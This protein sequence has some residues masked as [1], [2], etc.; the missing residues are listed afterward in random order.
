MGRPLKRAMNRAL[1]HAI[2]QGRV[3]KEDE[4]GTGGL[5]YSI[6]RIKGT[7]AAVLRERGP[8]TFEEIPPSELQLMA[9][10]LSQDEGFESGSDDQVR[11]VLA[12]FGLK[13]L[14]AQRRLRFTDVLGARDPNL[15]D[16][17]DGGK[18]Q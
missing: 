18:P 4:F 10:K 3:A 1:H 9:R 16:I 6:V 8:R 7:P 5:V 17:L 11:A 2:R 12:S 13:R 15:D 14:T